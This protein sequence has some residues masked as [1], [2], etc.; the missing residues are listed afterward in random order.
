MSYDVLI[1]KNAI[2][3][4]KKFP[5]RDIQRIKDTL[6]KLPDFPAGMDVKKM[7]GTRNIYRI[8]VGDYRICI[9]LANSF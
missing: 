1:D 4:I 3:E 6:K 5:S 2:R 7:A 9:C 8:K